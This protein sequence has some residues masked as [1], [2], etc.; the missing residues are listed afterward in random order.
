MAREVQ[1]RLLP[2]ASPQPRHAEIATAFL[3]ARSIG[4][5]IYDFMFAQCGQWA[6]DVVTE[7]RTECSK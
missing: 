5:D 2:S 4:G 1:L 7:C 3:P 6:E